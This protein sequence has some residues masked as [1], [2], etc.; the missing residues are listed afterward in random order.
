MEKLEVSELLGRLSGKEDDQV[1]ALKE[2]HRLAV[3]SRGST[4]PRGDLIRAARTRVSGSDEQR[5]FFCLEPE[6]PVEIQR[7]AALSLG[8]LGGANSVEPLKKLLNYEHSDSTTQSYCLSALRT[9]GGR[10][11]AKTIIDTLD[12]TSGRDV[13]VMDKALS[14]IVDLATGGSESDLDDA[15]VIGSSRAREQRLPPNS[16]RKLKTTLD[17]M[18]RDKFV[19]RRVRFRAN[20]VL[21][22]LTETGVVANESTVVDVNEE[23]ASVA[24]ESAWPQLEPP[25]YEF[26]GAEFLA[27]SDSLLRGGDPVPD[28]QKPREWN[29]HEYDLHVQGTPQ[30]AGEYRFEAATR[31]TELANEVIRFALTGVTTGKPN[32]EFDIKLDYHSAERDRWEGSEQISLVGLTEDSRL[33]LQRL[34]HD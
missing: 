23:A 7:R 9:I 19:P 6:Q 16:A 33:V 15:T 29:F 17:R 18:I 14:A 2:L 32:I 34:D 1:D 11:A 12:R 3:W 30:P 8:H 25:I 26:T 22:F 10:E 21:T 13:E 28:P 24:A 4:L 5:L 20:E 31:K 27:A